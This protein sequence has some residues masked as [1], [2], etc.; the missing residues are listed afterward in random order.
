MKNAKWFAIVVTVLAGLLVGCASQSTG[1]VKRQETETKEVGKK[2]TETKNSYMHTSDTQSELA[3]TT[4]SIDTDSVVLKV[5]YN[6]DAMEEGNDGTEYAL[7]GEQADF[8]SGLFYNHGKVINDSPP[9]SIASIEFRI[10][11][12]VLFTSIGGLST[13]DGGIKNQYVSIE[14]DDSERQQLRE[15]IESYVDDLTDL[16]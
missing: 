9:A 14:L 8:I 16:D 4:E 2:E 11:N 6:A 5:Y 1:Q 15:L 7:A 3:P 12:D 13:L 10:G